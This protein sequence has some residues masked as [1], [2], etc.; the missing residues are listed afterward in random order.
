MY[1]AS[2]RHKTVAYETIYSK[3]NLRRYRIGLDKYSVLDL[4]IIQCILYMIHDGNLDILFP[5]Q[6]QVSGLLGVH[7]RQVY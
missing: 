6:G 5:F 7:L 2:K 3:N 1:P 4:C